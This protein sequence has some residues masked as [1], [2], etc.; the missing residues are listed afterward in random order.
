[1]RCEVKDRDSYGRAVSRCVAGSV[2]LGEAMVRADWAVDDAQ[3]S[4]GAYGRTGADARQARR[5]LW[6]GRFETPSLWRADARRAQPAPAAPPTSGCVIK[7]N[8]NA[9]GRRIFHVPSQQDYAATRIDA[10]RGERWFCSA[11][12]AIAAGW[13][14]AAR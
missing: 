3:F 1:M 4:R 11:P 14:A 7:G 10:S 9:K 6:T 12:E 13:T 8:I 5:G 2:D